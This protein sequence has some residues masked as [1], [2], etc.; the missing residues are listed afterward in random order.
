MTPRQKQ[1][2]DFI[3]RYKLL[4]GISPSYEEIRIGIGA[5]SK[6]QVRAFVELL[7]AEG[8]LRKTQKVN[9]RSRKIQNAYRGLEIVEPENY[10]AANCPYC[11]AKAAVG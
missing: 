6:S 3:A 1:T 10:Q 11:G 8:A 5:S 2:L 9:W 4:N 7:I